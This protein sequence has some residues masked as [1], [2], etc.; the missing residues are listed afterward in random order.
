MIAAIVAGFLTAGSLY[1][2]DR[3][4]RLMGLNGIGDLRPM[5]YVPLLPRVEPV[6][7][8]SEVKE[9]HHRWIKDPAT[10]QM[11]CKDC[12]KMQSQ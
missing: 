11:Q 10:K 2:A 3:R 7:P 12:G 5:G 4:S 1:W 8:V 9:H 6:A